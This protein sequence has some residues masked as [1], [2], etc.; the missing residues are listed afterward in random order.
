MPMHITCPNCQTAYRVDRQAFGPDGR[1]VRCC[2][3]EHVWWHD[4]A[5]EE[6][7]L[8]LPDFPPTTE[9][10]GSHDT[11]PSG[12]DRLFDDRDDNQDKADGNGSADHQAV[13][14]ERPPTDRHAGGGFRGFT[15]FTVVAVLLL[16]AGAV[17][18][19]ARSQIVAL[20]PRAKA[21]YDLVGLDTT[22][23]GDGFTIRDVKTS[24]MTGGTT[25]VMFVRGVI[26]NIDAGEARIPLVRVI[27]LD[28]EGDEL[29]TVLH[30][31]RIRQLMPGGRLS[32]NIRID[33]PP[34][35][36]KRVDV[37]FAPHPQ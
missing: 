2:N 9:G 14:G 6:T 17:G 20:A 18:Y 33:R 34:K 16:A 19:L 26:A 7:A 10:P 25:D 32:F 11:R 30:D 5:G 1:R 23:P 4:V 37:A 31:V 21:V 12:N 29:K 13:A 3:C 27:L 35:Q 28:G 22:R 8:R 36:W 24:R 15:V